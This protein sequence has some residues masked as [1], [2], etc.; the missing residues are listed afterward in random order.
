MENPTINDLKY[1][2]CIVQLSRYFVGHM[3]YI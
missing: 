1:M 3:E 2:A